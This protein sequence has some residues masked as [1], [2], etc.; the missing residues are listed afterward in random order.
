MQ[1]NKLNPFRNVQPT[2]V[3]TE[4]FPHI[5]VEDALDEDVVSELIG[6]LPTPEEM[7]HALGVDVPENNKRLAYRPAYQKKMRLLSGTLLDAL[8]AQASK[9]FLLEFS[10]VFGGQ[11]RQQYPDREELFPENIGAASSGVRYIDSGK[12]I[13]IDNHLVVDTP[14]VE[15]P[16]AVRLPHVDHPRKFY[17]GLLYLRHPNDDSMGGDLE[18][19][20]AKA[21]P[22]QFRSK[23]ELTK[24]QLE[25]VK[26]VPYK[27]NLFIMI[28]NTPESIHGVSVRHPTAWPR[29]SLHP[30][31]ECAREMFPVDL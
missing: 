18:L 22:L 24:D 9:D 23:Y 28:L 16:S 1:F 8:C 15:Q 4:P 25:L 19:Y 7:A 31:G 3:I 5:I 14:V 13:L 2:D 30:T 6:E 12:D 20:R 29:Y 17:T 11:L 21:L 26:T 27:R 10:R